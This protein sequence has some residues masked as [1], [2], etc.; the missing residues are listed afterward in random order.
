[1][2]QVI[3]LCG[4]LLLAAAQCAL[5]AE[6]AGAKITYDGTRSVVL[7]KSDDGWTL[8]APG[9]KWSLTTAKDGTMSLRRGETLVASGKQ[10]KAELDLTS[11]AGRFLKL[12]LAAEKTHIWLDAEAKPIECKLKEGQI[13]V[14]LDGKELGRVKYYADT[15]KAKAKSAAD[16]E[17]AV[18]RDARGPTAALAPFLM[19]AEVPDE[20]RMA[21]VLLLFALDR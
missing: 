13:R 20:K 7:A 3:G 5:A 12:Q 19:G 16:Q 10:A 18:M 11:P 4:L 9:Q 2:K 14:S 6:T 1:M 17:V 8:D 15:K 21:L